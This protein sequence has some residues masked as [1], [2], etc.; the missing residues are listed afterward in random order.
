MNVEPLHPDDAAS[1][2]RYTILCD[3]GADAMGA[4]LGLTVVDQYCPPSKLPWPTGVLHVSGH[5]RYHLQCANTNEV[6]RYL[7]VAQRL[8]ILAYFD[9]TTAQVAEGPPIDEPGTLVYTHEAYGGTLRIYRLGAG[10]SF[11]QTRSRYGGVI[12]RRL[13]SPGETRILSVPRLRGASRR[14]LDYLGME[15]T[16]RLAHLHSPAQLARW[17]EQKNRPDWACLL[18]IEE[19]LGGLVSA[20]DDGSGS[21]RRRFGPW[22]VIQLEEELRKE[23]REPSDPSEPLWPFF[24]LR[25][26]LGDTELCLVGTLWQNHHDLAVDK[27]GRIYFWDAETDEVDIMAATGL[28]MFEKIAHIR[29]LRKRW[30]PFRLQVKADLG[31]AFAEHTGLTRVPETSDAISEEYLGPDSWVRRQLAVPPNPPETWIGAQRDEE[32]LRLALLA[33]A[34]DPSARM[35]INNLHLTDPE[36]IRTLEQLKKATKEVVAPW[37]P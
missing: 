29:E 12:D 33:H 2:P 13:I 20:P 22:L 31:A 3:S 36:Q 37:T 30:E 10:E 18:A 24:H 21:P 4:A 9:E 32:L 34:W 28:T 26:H 11:M 25:D 8:G 16:G 17:L 7:E 19:D 23:H 27:L 35:Q 6:E 5:G 15:R 14:L 1:G